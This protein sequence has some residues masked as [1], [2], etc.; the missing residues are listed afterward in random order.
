M[1]KRKALTSG[2]VGIFLFFSFTSTAQ[3]IQSTYLSVS[4]GVAS[5]AVNAVIQDKT[6]LLWL[7]TE[8]G[9]QNYDGYRFR[10]FRHETDNPNSLLHNMCWGITEDSNRNIWIGTD[11]GISR[12]DRKTNTFKNYP[13]NQSNPDIP[14]TGRTFFIAEDSHKRIWSA[15]TSIGFLQYDAQKDE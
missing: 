3:V 15:P 8:N 14:G 1:T 7:A 10:S 6:G 12:Y 4:D 11:N 13:F 2:L 5:S 9:I